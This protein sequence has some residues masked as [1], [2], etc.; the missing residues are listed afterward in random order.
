MMPRERFTLCA[1]VALLLS[2]CGPET[3][4]A[5]MVEDTVAVSTEAPAVT[6]TDTSSRSEPVEPRVAPDSSGRETEPAEDSVTERAAPAQDRGAEILAR[7]SVAYESLRSLQ[8]DFTMVLENPLLRRNT[9]SRGTLYQVSPDRILLRFSEPE[10][11]VIVGDGTH[12]WVY[13]PS[14][15]ADQVTRAPAAQAGSGGVDLRAQFV[16]DPTERFRYT[17]EGTEAVAGRPA[18]VLTLEP[19]AEAGYRSLKVWID[20]ADAMVRQFEIAEHNGAV[21]RFTFSSLQ[22][23]PA[24]DDALF[25]FTPPEGVRIVEPPR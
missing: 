22:R 19:R 4:G 20:E 12:F 24:L 11:D 6:A 2:G 25:R 18:Q 23:N 9:T 17:V 16:G 1:A 21:R 10:G 8:A 5:E 13:Y 7:A 3:D 14:V 15:N